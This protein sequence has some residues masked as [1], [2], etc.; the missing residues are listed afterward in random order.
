[1]PRDLTPPPLSPGEPEPGKRVR[2]TV[3]SFAETEVH[4]TLYL[5]K[6]WSPSEKFP[7]LVEYA[8]NGDYKNDYGD[9][10]T[11]RVEDCVLGYGVGGGSRFIWIC[12]PFVSE[13]G[14][15]N[16]I[17]WWGSV[18]KTIDYCRGAVDEVCEHWGGD[19]DQIFLMGFS[20]GAIACNF[21]GL[22]NDEIA[23]LW[24]GFICHSHYD[25]VKEWNYAG[26]D[27]AAAA[28][29]LNRLE[30]RPQWISHEEST[31]PTR[32]YLMEAAPEGNFT[33]VDIPYRN[34]SAEWVLCD[35]PERQ[36]LRD[37]IEA[38][39]SNDVGGRP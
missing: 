15:E 5:P 1:V 33:F 26:S 17:R 35:I 31:Q 30:G 14:T 21:I 2:Q 4:H 10:C 12:L 13:S 25:G 8:G 3:Q 38:V 27:R 32:E 36:A 28:V 7:V 19:R 9:V 39:L 20:R 34:H 6:D 24:R 16:Q 37:W 22:H 11:G 18:E 29:R 23:S